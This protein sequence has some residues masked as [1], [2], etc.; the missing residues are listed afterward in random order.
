V[1][2]R[3]DTTREKPPGAAG[4]L[5]VKNINLTEFNGEN[6]EHV[7]RYLPTSIRG[8]TVKMAVLVAREKETES[9]RERE[10]EREKER[11]SNCR[12]VGFIITASRGIINA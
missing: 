11:D 10:R 7:I 8:F 12:F 2:I 5:T 6:G 4:L 1:H 3:R 9:E